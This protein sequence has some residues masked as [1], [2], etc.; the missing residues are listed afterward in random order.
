MMWTA[1]AGLLRISEFTVRSDKEPSRMLT[2][3]HLTLHDQSQHSF[4]LNQTAAAAE[5]I[6][7][8]TLHLSYRFFLGGVSFTSPY[9]T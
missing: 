6:E 8:A 5:E 7:Y 3:D 2:M 9:S 4:S 1:T